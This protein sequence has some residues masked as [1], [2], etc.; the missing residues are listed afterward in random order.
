MMVK[1]GLLELQVG[2]KS[3]TGYFCKENENEST[4][5]SLG[6]YLTIHEIRK[7]QYTNYSS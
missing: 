4:K 6:N 3:C 2:F 5:M 1:F 7:M